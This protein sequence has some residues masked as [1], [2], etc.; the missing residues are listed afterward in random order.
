MQKTRR[1]S[2]AG[3]M[4]ANEPWWLITK[5]RSFS[6]SATDLLGHGTDVEKQ[7][8]MQLQRSECFLPL[9]K[10]YRGGEPFRQVIALVFV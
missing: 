6:C 3:L 8:H 2:S 7:G 9:W 1:A 10:Y 4:L 5:A